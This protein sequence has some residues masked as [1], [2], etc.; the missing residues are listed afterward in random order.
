[1]VESR[2][3]LGLAVL[4]GAAY[5]LAV[6]LGDYNPEGNGPVAAVVFLTSGVAIAVLCVLLGRCHRRS[7]ALL[8][9]A[10]LAI[11]VE[12][13]D[14]NP[15]PLVLVVG[16]WLVGR[17][18]RAHRDLVAALEARAVEL[19]AGRASFIHE[20]LRLERTRMARELHDVVAHN[21]SVIVVQASAGRRLPE[22]TPDAHDLRQ[23]IRELAGQAR[24]DV[25]NLALLLEPS[26]EVS[27]R[28]SVD[29]LIAR[30]STAGSPVRADIRLN[31]DLLP[32]Q[33]GRVV[34]RVIQES[35]TNALKHAPGAPI[36][37]AV[38]GDVTLQVQVRNA[39]SSDRTPA[40][41][42]SGR[43][44]V[45]LAERLAELG[46]SVTAGPRPEGGW[47]VLADLPR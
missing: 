11:A 25:A 44:L 24:R 23:T 46:G 42:G 14:I 15:F 22:D 45:G 31:L 21:L 2:W 33:V 38:S 35:L 19:E 36:V 43:G 28:R 32:D 34:Q 41:P 40:A 3:P 30:T 1:M 20:A 16:F 39:E 27:C 26:S 47:Q 13:H 18:V 6:Q 8:G 4:G 5:L 10:V 12:W 9:P 29:E 7:D 37:V 17:S